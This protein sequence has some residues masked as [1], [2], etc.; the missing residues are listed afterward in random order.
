MN[1]HIE[2]AI[3]KQIMPRS[4]FWNKNLAEQREIIKRIKSLK[5]KEL[6]WLLHNRK[7]A[8]WPMDADCESKPSSLLP[9][10]WIDKPDHMHFGRFYFAIPIYFFNDE[11]DCGKV[12]LMAKL[13]FDNGPEHSVRR[14]AFI[15]AHQFIRSFTRFS[16]EDYSQSMTTDATVKKFVLDEKALKIMILGERY[17]FLSGFNYS[18]NLRIISYNCPN[19]LW[20]F[21]YLFREYGEENAICVETFIKESTFSRASEG[22]GNW[23]N[24][25][26]DIDIENEKNETAFM[27]KED[28]MEYLHS[29]K[30]PPKGDFP[31]E[32]ECAG[33]IIEEVR[34]AA[35]ENKKNVKRQELWLKTRFRKPIKDIPLGK[36]AKK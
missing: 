6:Y 33:L 28:P 18:P 25:I 31:P 2:S 16:V 19:S 29:S 7:S 30:G 3:E 24:H 13:E 4:R 23:P 22:H 32:L 35:V 17:T 9:N 14:K 11:F 26:K 21:M 5:K 1:N 20:C 34:N 15:F 8:I 27:L 12:N 10:D 36:K